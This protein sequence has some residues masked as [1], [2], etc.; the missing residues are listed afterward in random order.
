MSQASDSLWRRIFPKK[1]KGMSRWDNPPPPPDKPPTV[2]VVPTRCM[3]G[4][5]RYWVSIDAITQMC[6]DCKFQR[7]NP[8]VMPSNYGKAG[9]PKGATLVFPVSKPVAHERNIRFVY[10]DIHIVEIPG[11]PR[12]PCRDN[13][14]WAMTYS[15]RCEACGFYDA[16]ITRRYMTGTPKK[17]TREYMIESFRTHANRH[18]ALGSWTREP[19]KSDPG[20]EVNHI[21]HN[22]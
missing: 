13:I 15:G 9:H 16:T 1:K 17:L 14:H 22:T 3:N 6:G 2:R 7:T 21:Y 11:P 8:N 18:F 4:D 19:I 5:H 12:L 20:D 10:G